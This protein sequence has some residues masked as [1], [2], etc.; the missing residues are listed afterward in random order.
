[1]FISQLAIKFQTFISNIIS[2]AI[3][4]KTSPINVYTVLHW[5]VIVIDINQ[6]YQSL[7]WSHWAVSHCVTVGL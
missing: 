6:F 4:F 1:M 3:G 5:T 7:D 2:L